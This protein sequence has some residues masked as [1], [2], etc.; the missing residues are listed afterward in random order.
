MWSDKCVRQGRLRLGGELWGVMH[1]EPYFSHPRNR[2][3]DAHF[4]WLF[5]GLDEAMPSTY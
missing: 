3:N 4:L 2:D 1:A 5:Y